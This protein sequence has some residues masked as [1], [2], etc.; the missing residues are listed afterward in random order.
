MVMK[1]KTLEQ[2][3]HFLLIDEKLKIRMNVLFPFLPFCL[4]LNFNNLNMKNIKTTLIV[5]QTVIIIG[6]IG[7]FYSCNNNPVNKENSET[8]E[9]QTKVQSSSETQDA[10]AM[11]ILRPTECL[12]A[13]EF[14][15]N[16][17][18]FIMNPVQNPEYIEENAVIKIDTT[19]LKQLINKAQ[20]SYIVAVFG[21][22]PKPEDGKVS[23][24]L[25]LFPVDSNNVRVPLYPS[26]ANPY[27]SQVEEMYPSLFT[28]GTVN[29]STLFNCPD[30]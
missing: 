25:I 14:A 13:L 9:K 10:K 8:S 22:G 21:R 11:A 5:A 16:Y 4:L 29:Y 23:T 24:K 20:N 12:T 26:A 7:F 19:I 3:F 1:M 2:M 27:N 30:K 15:N 28:I 6:L 17:K 18:T